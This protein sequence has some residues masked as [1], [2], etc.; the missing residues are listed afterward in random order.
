LLGFRSSRGREDSFPQQRL[1][2]LLTPLPLQDSVSKMDSIDTT[3]EV[4]HLM[5]HSKSIFAGDQNGFVSPEGG[6]MP[7]RSMST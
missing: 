1:V 3:Q 6:P 4:V 2:S 7:A 5:A